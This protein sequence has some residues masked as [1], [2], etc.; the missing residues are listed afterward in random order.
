MAGGRR[1]G[2][3]A[4]MS[5]HVTEQPAA[6]RLERATTERMVAGVCGGLGRYFDLNP[7]F[8]RIAFVVLTLL[9]G[10][11][12]LIYGAALLIVPEEGVE[13]SIAARVLKQN[14]DKPW[15]VVG[16]A[17]VAVASILLLQSL[18]FHP[19]GDGILLL[20]LAA[21]LLLLWAHARDE[22][23]G[24]KRAVRVVA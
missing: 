16:F 17:L 11:G 22:R 12:L 9:G 15:A 20:V 8:F 3:G 21:G 7:A 10:S 5:E 4:A 1:D 24:R 13:D 6:R 19:A 2:Q 18:R 23:A 14:R